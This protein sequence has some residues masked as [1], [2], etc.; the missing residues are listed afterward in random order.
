[1]RIPRSTPLR[2]ISSL[3]SQLSTWFVIEM[4]MSSS[5]IT[6]IPK[7]FCG[8]RVLLVEPDKSSLQH[9]ADMLKQNSYRVTTTTKVTNGLSMLMSGHTYNCVL[10]DADICETDMADFL[11][12]VLR[13]QPQMSI[14]LMASDDIHLRIPKEALESEA[15]LCLLKPCGLR[16]ICNIWKH[17]CRNRIS[18]EEIVSNNVQRVNRKV[19][20][21]STNNSAA[22]NNNISSG[23]DIN[24][25]E[26]T[27]EDLFSYDDGDDGYNQEDVDEIASKENVGIGTMKKADKGKQPFIL[28]RKNDQP[29]EDDKYPKRRKEI[30]TRVT[31]KGELDEKFNRALKELG[32]QAQSSAI[33]KHMNVP[34][35]TRFHVASHLQKY[36]KKQK[37][38]EASIAALAQ[39]GNSLQVESFA[40][41]RCRFSTQYDDEASVID[42]SSNLQRS[43]KL[44]LAGIFYMIIENIRAKLK[45]APPLPVLQ[46]ITTSINNYCGD[47][48][49]GHSFGEAMSP[50]GFGATVVSDYNMKMQ[51]SNNGN[52]GD[53]S[54]S[55]VCDVQEQ[56]ACFGP[57]TDPWVAGCG[58]VAALLNH[59]QEDLTLPDFLRPGARSLCPSQDFQ[60]NGENLY[61]DFLHSETPFDSENCLNPGSNLDS[62]PFGLTNADFSIPEF[63]TEE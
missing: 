61:P 37:I 23:N 5:A 53:A 31:W 11:N 12:Q 21:S 24:S 13:H 57:A 7:R 15:V 52:F 40:N 38:I 6:V 33:L 14:V 19:K 2:F 4:T 18:F 44:N 22:I 54:G 50:L 26:V 25:Q 60:V 56:L 20:P 41:E 39:R 51:W 32:K 10:I 46:V 55:G 43:S 35:L 49:T 30:K 62:I 8:L 27:Y 36:Q 47:Q 48:A 59:N 16:D 58:G 17:I 45:E 34:G 29:V 9:H 3:I 63:P 1:M 28:K 42:Q